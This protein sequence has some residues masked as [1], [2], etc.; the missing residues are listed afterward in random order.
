MVSELAQVVDGDG[1]GRDW[2]IKLVVDLGSV[3]LNTL[4]DTTSV[5]EILDKHPVLTWVA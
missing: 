2:L 4:K 5:T 1:P 3:Q